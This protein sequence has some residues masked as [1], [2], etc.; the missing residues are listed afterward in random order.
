[1]ISSSSPAPVASSA[2]IW[3]R[4]LQQRGHTKIRAVDVKPLDE[5]YQT[6]DDVENLVGDL[7]LLEP[8]RAAA[9]GARDDLQPRRRHGR[10]GLHREQQGPVH[11]VGADQHAHADGRA[12][13][14]ASS[15]SSIRSS[16]CVY[17]ADKQ[18]ER[19]RHRRSRKRTP[20]RRCRRTATA[21][22]SCSAS[23]CAATSARTSASHTRVARFHNVYGPHGTWDGGR[24]KAPAAICRK[25]I[26]AKLIG[27]AR[28]RDLGRRQA[29]PQLH[30]HRRLHR[31]H[32]SRSRTATSI[33]PL[34]LGSRRAGHASTAWS[35]S[36]RTSPA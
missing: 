3:S 7:A 33:E 26:D 36:S 27:Q 6:F 24:E 17:N 12:R 4:V 28:D 2:A 16:A 30:V 5:W 15:G 31:G 14:P 10:H 25:V 34:N 19:R 35:T 11:A 1:M 20:T 23:G 29:D 22:R 8:C 18:T 32:R 9:K 21:G 13:K